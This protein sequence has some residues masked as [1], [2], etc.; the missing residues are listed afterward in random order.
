MLSEPLFWSTIIFFG[1]PLAFMAWAWWLL[2]TAPNDTEHLPM[3][4]ATD[5][6]QTLRNVRKANWWRAQ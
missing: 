3:G 2:W 1:V 4:D 6:P 5:T